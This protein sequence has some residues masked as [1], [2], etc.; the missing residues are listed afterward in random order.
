M[1]AKRRLA[2]F[3]RQGHIGLGGSFGSHAGQCQG[4]YGS[5][6]VSSVQIALYRKGGHL[7]SHLLV[8]V[9]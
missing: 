1:A 4:A 8:C 2:V 7:S 9:I 6:A 5:N 3:K